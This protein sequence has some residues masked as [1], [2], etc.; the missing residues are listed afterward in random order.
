MLQ[1]TLNL[2]QG[3]L[4][5]LL[6]CWL[7]VQVFEDSLEQKQSMPLLLRCVETQDT[8]REMYPNKWTMIF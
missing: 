5:L 1:K 2:L 7:Y 3:T 8:H 6:D 4:S